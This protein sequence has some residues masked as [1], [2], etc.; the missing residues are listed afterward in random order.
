MGSFVFM[1]GSLLRKIDGNLSMNV[2]EIAFV[3]KW[4]EQRAR[5]LRMF[6]KVEW[7]QRGIIILESLFKIVSLENALNVIS[8]H[9]N[10]TFKFSLFFLA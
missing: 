5:K 6:P 1:L 8:R 3:G 7:Q 9:D 4:Q 10:G 2:F